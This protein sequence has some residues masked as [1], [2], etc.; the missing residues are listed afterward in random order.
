MPAEIFRA[1]D[2]YDLSEW[3]EEQ[4]A[5]Y[6]PGWYWWTCSPGCLPDGPPQG[7]FDTEA[8]AREDAEDDD[9]D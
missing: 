4:G 3:A 7:P 5:D 9:F 6:P 8:E 1:P 2:D